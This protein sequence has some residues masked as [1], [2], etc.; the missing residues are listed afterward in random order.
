MC[1]NG[2]PIQLK[3]DW[4]EVSLEDTRRKLENRGIAVVNEQ[5][6]ESGIDI[7]RRILRAAGFSDAAVEKEVFENPG[8]DAAE[9]VFQW[10]VTAMQQSF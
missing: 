10:F 7:F 6:G 5:R 3:Y 9:E 2:R 4:S 8:F 1:I